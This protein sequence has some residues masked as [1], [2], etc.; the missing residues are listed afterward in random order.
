MKKNRSVQPS[1]DT[2]IPTLCKA[3]LA[4]MGIIAFVLI[5]TMLVLAYIVG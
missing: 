3:M 2:G 5:V 1:R 4:G